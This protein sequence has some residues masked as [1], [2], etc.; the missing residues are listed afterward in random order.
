MPVEHSNSVSQQNLSD[1]KEEMGRLLETRSDNPY[2]NALKKTDIGDPEALIDKACCQ[3]Y[4]GEDK[5]VTLLRK[6]YEDSNNNATAKEQLTD[7]RIEERSAG[8]KKSM[9]LAGLAMVGALAL[10]ITT[11]GIGTAFLA[12][13]ATAAMAAPVMYTGLI[14]AMGLGV[15]S[16]YVDDISKNNKLHKKD[17]HKYVSDMSDEKASSELA[18]E[19]QFEADSILN[20]GSLSLNDRRDFVYGSDKERLKK[21]KKVNKEPS[22]NLF[23]KALNTRRKTSSH[24]ASVSMGV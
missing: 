10:S 18:S 12:G 7:R 14:S 4:K 24:G 22:E 3:P 15:S 20:K 6:G 11:M 1:R 23:Q 16:V 9:A 21:V 17:P 5:R 19:K 13:V 2:I 8:R